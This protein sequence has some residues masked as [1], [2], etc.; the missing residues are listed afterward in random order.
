MIP[1]SKKYTGQRIGI[2]TE[3]PLTEWPEGFV[4]D[5]CNFDILPDGSFKRRL[6]LKP[7]AS[8]GWVQGNY[9][10]EDVVCRTTTWENPGY[11]ANTYVNVIQFGHRLYFYN[12][13][14]KA[15][16]E[17]RGLTQGAAV[18]ETS[19]ASAVAPYRASY[20][21]LEQFCVSG[22]TLGYQQSLI[23]KSPCSFA[24]GK[25]NLYVTHK[26]LSPFYVTYDPATNEIE[27]V[28][29][30]VIQRDYLGVDDGILIDEQPTTL[31]ESHRY[32]LYNRGWKL[33][34]MNQ[35]YTD[36]SKYPA[37]NM[38]SRFAYLRY[39]DPGTVTAAKYY[40]PEEGIKE[41]SSTK[42]ENELFGQESAPQGHLITK[43]WD[44]TQVWSGQ[45]SGDYTTNPIESVA[46]VT[47]T[48]SGVWRVVVNAT[49][50]GL[51]V[52]DTTYISGLVLKM[53][54]FSG[55]FTSKGN[56]SINDT[57]TVQTVPTANQFSFDITIS[58][59]YTKY[60]STVETG[61]YTTA[62][63]AV[64]NTTYGKLL[65]TRFRLNAF[66]LGRV[67]YAGLDEEWAQNRVYFSQVVDTDDKAGR[68]TT[69]ADP[70]SKDISDP[71]VTDGGYIT[72]TDAN[73]IHKLV[74]YGNSM[75]VFASGGVWQLGPGS[76][77][78]FSPLSYSIRK[79]SDKGTLSDS[80][81]VLAE[82][83]PVYWSEEAIF[84]V[85]EDSNTGYLTTQDLSTNTINRM[86]AQITPIGKEYALGV[87]DP[88]DKR[89][90][91]FY[92]GLDLSSTELDGST[93]FGKIGPTPPVALDP[94]NEH[95]RRP[96]GLVLDLR[97]GGFSRYQLG[98]TPN[99]FVWGTFS[100]PAKLNYIRSQQ[101]KLLVNTPVNGAPF[102][103]WQE[104]A[105][106]EGD[107][108][109]TDWTYPNDSGYEKYDSFIVSGPETLGDAGRLKQVPYVHTMF[110]RVEGSDCL[111]QPV[112]DWSKT[113]VT[114]NV[115]NPQRVYR[116]V[117]PNASGSKLIVTKNKILGRGYS[118]YLGFHA[119]PGKPCWLEGWRVEYGVTQKL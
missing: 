91:W 55:V 27:T 15:V 95:Y 69:V 78:Y 9:N 113:T 39:A 112:W 23:A 32:N 97:T 71:V 18:M 62:A 108:A 94:T 70:T 29:Y 110:R 72:L 35:Y 30:T 64:G 58:Q 54:F 63:P 86:Y 16:M 83:T 59:L 26:H 104:F 101:L 40:S 61:Y 36:K 33:A 73:T 44:T 77:G 105:S 42:L 11:L 1:A 65:S 111:M 8:A 109:Y 89:V 3:A 25:G 53:E 17:S 38:V 41:F 24:F 114:G 60:L 6:G 34:E 52:S 67:W 100:W 46:S 37:K 88:M 7:E 21:D 81:I 115:G 51:S 79:I 74:P 117:Q 68:C 76:L 10:F 47:N 93:Y 19:S 2:N 84:A 57:Y 75:L 49:S 12:V 119:M 96:H 31:S 13:P 66:H 20:I 92:G 99:T 50:H 45:G 28:E 4:M 14:S 48:S 103:F 82:T 5:S 116:E 106:S 98:H 56:V 85:V 118:L 102:A 87:Y 43:V 90:F 22:G 107:T 80:S